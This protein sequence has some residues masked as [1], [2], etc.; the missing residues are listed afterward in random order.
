MGR[1]QAGAG[2]SARPLFVP[3]DPPGSEFRP[4]HVADT[5][6]LEVQKLPPR[7]A[8]KHRA[9]AAKDRKVP[10]HRNAPVGQPPPAG[11]IGVAV[12]EHEGR[13]DRAG[14]DRGTTGTRN[15]RRA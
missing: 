11:R 13:L 3:K 9:E 12:G 15:L 4:S 7:L 5:I 8:F 1:E 14:I 10:R 2:H 6:G